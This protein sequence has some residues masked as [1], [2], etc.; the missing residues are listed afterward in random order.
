[1]IPGLPR[2]RLTLAVVLMGSVMVFMAGGVLG[3]NQAAQGEPMVRDTVEVGEPIS[4][5]VR[6]DLGAEYPTA[7]VSLYLGIIG[8]FLTLADWGSVIGYASVTQIGAQA[9][10]LWMGGVVAGTYLVATVMIARFT[11][12]AVEVIR[13]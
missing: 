7:V 3:A 11:R 5:A 9:T 12:D 13:A 2:G 10:R 1:M 8:P 6:A 4:E